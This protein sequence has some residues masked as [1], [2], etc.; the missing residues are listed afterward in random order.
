MK[1]NRAYLKE[2][3]R[4]SLKVVDTCLACIYSG[5]SHM[6][7]A[8]AGQLR[9]LLCDTQRSRDNSLIVAVYPRLEV[10]A[11]QSVS[12]SSHQAGYLRLTQSK[13]GTTRIAQMPFE[14]TRYANGLAVADLQIDGTELLTIEQWRNQP[15][16]YHPTELHLAE[17]IRS[18]ADKGGGAHVDQTLS[19]ALQYMRT[20]TPVGETY[21]QL[22]IVAVGR[23]IQAL[24]EHL[25]SYRGCR[26]PTELI[27]QKHDKYNLAIAA[28]EDWAASRGSANTF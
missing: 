27:N 11:L 19:P 24:G 21:A 4:E 26:V 15:V 3:L 16:T 10:S 7:R 12:W 17:V 18:V 25:F 13:N 20:A 6:Y 8:L 1:E 2:Q 22:L 14:I 28:H 9:I 23:F 5:E